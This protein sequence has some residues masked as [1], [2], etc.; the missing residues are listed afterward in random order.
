[1][2]ETKIKNI[3]NKH[4]EEVCANCQNFVQFSEDMQDGFCI[5]NQDPED[6]SLG[7]T[8]TTAISSCSSFSVEMESALQMSI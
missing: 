1:M 6:T 5:L 2:M 8:E 3:N 7:N 4:P